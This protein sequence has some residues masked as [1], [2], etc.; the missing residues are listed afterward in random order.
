[1][2]TTTARQTAAMLFMIALSGYGLIGCAEEKAG[3]SEA[4]GDRGKSDELSIPVGTYTLV[5]GQTGDFESLTLSD[6]GTFQATHRCGGVPV[7]CFAISLQTGTYS[8]EARQLTLATDT[9]EGGEPTEDVYSFFLT[10]TQSVPGFKTV[11]HLQNLADNGLAFSMELAPPPRAQEGESCGG[12]V[13]H[14]EQCAIGLVC[15]A[16]HNPPIPDVPGICVR[17]DSH[18]AGSFCTDFTRCD[19]GLE[20]TG[21]NGGPGLC[22]RPS[23]GEGHPEGSFCT[24]FTHCDAGLQCTGSNGGPGVCATI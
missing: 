18:P 2:E 23:S 19:P 10:T 9:L 12:L 7:K 13:A 3:T 1:M 14:A 22:A 21:S 11:L 20:C 4:Q 15:Q 6:D 8:V 16:A 5:D 24:D 17:K